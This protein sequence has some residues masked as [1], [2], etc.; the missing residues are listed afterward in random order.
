MRAENLTWPDD[1]SVPPHAHTRDILINSHIEILWDDR[2]WQ[3][4]RRRARVY[5]VKGERGVKSC[6]SC[7]VK[8]R[9]RSAE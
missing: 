7:L 6:K 1:T 4:A 8:E 2:A 9:E 3:S 5:V